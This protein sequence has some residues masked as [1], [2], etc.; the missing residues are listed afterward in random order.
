ML[1]QIL[2][3]L[4][5]IILVV[6]ALILILLHIPRTFWVEFDKADLLTVK[7]R[8]LFFKVKVYRMKKEEKEEM[9][10]V[11]VCS[12]VELREGI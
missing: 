1:I 8:I 4:G 9:L 10:A 6:L 7:A 12:R 11:Q 3:I 5:I 2:K